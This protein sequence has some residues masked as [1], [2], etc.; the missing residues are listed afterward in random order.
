M[1]IITAFLQFHEFQPPAILQALQ[2]PIKHCAASDPRAD[3][4][5][6]I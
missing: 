3:L 5:P 6:N 4:W 1:N 2:V